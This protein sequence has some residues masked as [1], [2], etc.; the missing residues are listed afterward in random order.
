MVRATGVLLLGALMVVLSEPRAAAQSNVSPSPVAAPR[1]SDSKQPDDADERSPEYRETVVVTATS[2][3]QPLSNVAAS[4]SVLTSDQISRTPVSSLAEA[5]RSVPGVDIARLTGLAQSGNSQFTIRGVP[6]TKRALMLVDGMAGNDL[7]YGTLV[8]LDLLPVNGIQRVEVVRGPFSGLYGANAFG[9]VMNVMTRRGSGRLTVEPFGAVGSAGY[10]QV[11]LTT[12]GGNRR[13]AFSLTADQRHIDNVYGRSAQTAFAPNADSTALVASPQAIVNYGYDDVRAIA[14]FDATLGERVTLTL[15]PRISQRDSGLG[16]STQLPT[17][18]DHRNFGTNVDLGVVLASSGS[19]DWQWTVRHGIR[20]GSAELYQQNFTT[21]SATQ[22][23]TLRPGPVPVVSSTTSQFPYAAMTR[24]DSSYRTLSIDPSA[25]WTGAEHHTLTVGFNY[26]HETGDFSP[27]YITNSTNVLGS[28]AMM[29]GIAASI[30]AGLLRG[31]APNPTVTYLRDQPIGNVFPKTDGSRPVV[32]SGGVYVQD[33]WQATDRL[34]V[35]PGLRL[36]SHSQFGS[37]ASPKFGATYAVTPATRLRM[38]AGRAYRAPSLSELYGTIIFHGPIPGYPNAD[39]RP[40]YINAV[41]GGIAHDFSSNTR[42][43]GGLFF[44]DM[45]DL[46]TLRL[47]AAGDHFDWVNV[48]KARSAGTEWTATTRPVNWLGLTG[49]YGHTWSRDEDTRQP[50]DDMPGNMVFFTGEAVRAF[51]KAAVSTSLSWR[52]Y[53]ER[54]T[55]YRSVATTL[56]SY[57]RADAAVSLAWGERARVGLSVQNLLNRTF[58][59]TAVNLAPARMLSLNT[60]L[61]F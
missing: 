54:F 60:S 11:G 7:G 57:S 23:I 29:A 33:E 51:G 2:T 5:L 14:R 30:Q 8:G 55:I 31:G 6:G 1:A 3:A 40:E 59:E 44:N 36:D 32:D 52:W 26:A 47:A 16:Q 49:F 20:W 13:V 34:R 15:L 39:L 22:T 46:V 37:V 24:E 53:G 28:D 48:S 50:I 4:V 10:N 42:I 45:T 27:H 18:D 56:P 41:D 21:T 35:T 17:P 43:E 58:Q 9:G 25:T 12:Q 38:S 61:R 19:S